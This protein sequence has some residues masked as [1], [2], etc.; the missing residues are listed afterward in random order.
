M[1]FSLVDIDQND[2]IYITPLF[3]NYFKTVEYMYFIFCGIL[4]VLEMC[5]LIHLH[6]DTRS[7]RSV[8]DI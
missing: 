2:E 4:F 6:V 3:R 8:C 1:T 7:S 5:L